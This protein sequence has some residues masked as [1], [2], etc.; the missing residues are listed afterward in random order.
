MEKILTISVASYNM[1]KLISE[2]ILSF[3]NSKYRDKIELLI[4]NDGSK[5]NTVEVVNKYVELYP[6]MVKLINKENGGAGSTVNKGIELATGKYF[7]MVDGDDYV[8]D[9]T[10]DAFIEFLENNDLDLVVSNYSLI[11]A[12]SKKVIEKKTF[13]LPSLF[14]FD[15]CSNNVPNEM[16]ALTYKTSIM[17]Q[18]PKLDNGFYTDVEYVLYPIKY[19]KKCGF[20]NNN[21][22]M[23][24]V[25]QNEQS[26]NPNRMMKNIAAHEIVVNSL[27]NWFNTLEDISLEKKKFIA[28]RICVMTRN[29]VVTLLYFDINKENYNRV[30]KFINSQKKNEYLYNI[31]KNSK[32][33]KTIRYFKY[34]GYKFSSKKIKKELNM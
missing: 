29:N 19:V 15:E 4:I 5:D 27:C 14:D 22:Y 21:V 6:E 23:Y 2:N 31:F 13:D 10:L 3:A 30:K 32:L 9:K 33:L 1:E 11:D 18:I 28:F 8:D 7:R 34:L 20:F 26:V 25:G 17:K 12:D 16:H 24:R